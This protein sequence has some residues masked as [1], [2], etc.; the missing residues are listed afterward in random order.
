MDLKTTGKVWT[1]MIKKF[2]SSKKGSTK[3]TM[4]KIKVDGLVFSSLFDTGAQASCIKYDTIT[5]LGL[6][7][8]IS[9]ININVRNANGQDMG[10]R[11]SVLVNFKYDRPV[12]LI[13]LLFVKD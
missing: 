7:S 11:G 2:C 10:V 3:G 6:I 4:F 1:E 9:D 13:N 5:A 8:Q 12:S